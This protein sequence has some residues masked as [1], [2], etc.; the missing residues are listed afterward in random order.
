MVDVLLGAAIL[1]AAGAIGRW[2]AGRVHT[3]RLCGLCLQASVGLGVISLVFLAIGA[4]GAIYAWVAWAL[5]WSWL[6]S[7]VRR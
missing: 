1:T 2:L 5:L 3:D 7:D 4:I 6:S